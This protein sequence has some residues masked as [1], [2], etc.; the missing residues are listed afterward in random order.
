MLPNEILLMIFSFAP[1]GTTNNP[2]MKYAYLSWVC[3]HWRY[4]IVNTPTFWAELDLNCR[5]YALLQTIFH[6]SKNTA[7][8]VIAGGPAFPNYDDMNQQIVALEKLVFPN[9]DRVYSLSLKLSCSRYKEIY[10]PLRRSAPVLKH[11]YLYRAVEDVIPW[12]P[13]YHYHQMDEHGSKDIN[14]DYLFD[15]ACSLESLT[16]DMPQPIPWSTFEPM[17]SNIRELTL[18]TLLWDFPQGCSTYSSLLVILDHCPCLESL[19]LRT[20]PDR[21][22]YDIKLISPKPPVVNLS[23]LSKLVLGTSQDVTMLSYITFPKLRKL[24]L[25]FDRA[26]PTSLALRNKIVHSFDHHSLRQAVIVD[27]RNI[28]AYPDLALINNVL[29]PIGTTFRINPGTSTLAITSDPAG[30]VS[31]LIAPLL[32]AMI[33]LERLV[34]ISSETNR[35]GSSTNLVRFQQLSL[36]DVDLKNPEIIFKKYTKRQS[37]SLWPFSSLFQGSNIHPPLQSYQ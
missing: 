22:T 14:F 33:S 24:H 4:L 2:M 12:T 1:N 29:E 3:Q 37:F 6:R 32:T 16:F 36:S 27:E 25:H 20:I 7:L 31:A 15:G 11:L 17:I 5:N 10:I 18:R 23:R 9:M 34:T 35:D 13:S 8:S 19:D 26:Y 21:S 28:L 30:S